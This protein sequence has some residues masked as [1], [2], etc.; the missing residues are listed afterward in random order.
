MK[1]KNI[2]LLICI[3]FLSSCKNDNQK[4]KATEPDAAVVEDFIF[5]VKLGFVAAQNDNFHIYYTE[6]GSIDFNEEQSIWA[7][8]KGS[9]QPQEL[10]FNLPEGA[11]PTNLRIDF[12]GGPNPE[13][14]QIMLQKFGM[15]YHGKKFEVQGSDIFKF[16]Y[17][18]EQ[19]T[20]YDASAG[21]LKRITPDDQTA[22][23]LYPHLTLSAEIEKLLN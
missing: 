12:G 18:N 23:S 6:D 8:V 20:V 4:E 21:A 14:T 11:L 9:N 3:A 15:E 10:V 13:Q 22:P 5:K 7:E 19:N 17:P 2:L 16:F 1:F